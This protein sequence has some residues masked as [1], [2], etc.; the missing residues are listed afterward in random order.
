MFYLKKMIEYNRSQE[1][2]C[3]REYQLYLDNHE[4]L[5]YSPDSRRL[6]RVQKIVN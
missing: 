3:V 6:D 4:T 1:S 2:I 5:M